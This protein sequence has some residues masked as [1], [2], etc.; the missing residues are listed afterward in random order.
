MR[1]FTFLTVMLL[2]FAL[3]HADKGGTEAA[4][5]IAVKAGGFPKGQMDKPTV[6]ASAEELAKVTA[7]EAS[8]ESIKKE[9]DFRKEKLVYFAWSGSGQ[10]KITVGTDKD[11]KGGAVVV[12]GLVR[13]L[14]RDLRGHTRLFVIGKDANFVVRSAR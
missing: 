1:L 13:G 8:V 5:E 3:V 11:E 6:I 4:R 14:T 2:S 10:D 9:V 12:F 7:L